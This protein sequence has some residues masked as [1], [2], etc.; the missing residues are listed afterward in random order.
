MKR[1]AGIGGVFFK[2]RDPQTLRASYR[3]RLGTDI[4]DRDGMAF[5]GRKPNSPDQQGTTIRSV[6]EKSSNYFA[7][8]S[9]S[10]AGSWIRKATASNSG[11][12]RIARQN[13]ANRT[14][15]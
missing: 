7:P 9:A 1:V 12:R 8:S 6:F 15:D 10:S 4:Q 3:D 13:E 5:K 2:A 11:G 14:A